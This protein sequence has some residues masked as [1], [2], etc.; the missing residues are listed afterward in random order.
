MIFCDMVEDS[1]VA[2]ERNIVGREPLSVH[3]IKANIGYGKEKY[4]TLNKNAPL[5]YLQ[6]GEEQY[7]KKEVSLSYNYLHRGMKNSRYFTGSLGYVY[8][9][10]FGDVTAT[11]FSSITTFDSANVRREY[12]KDKKGY[13]INKTPYEEF[14]NF[15]ADV[16][17]Q[18]FFG[19]N[20]TVGFDVGSNLSMQMRKAG[21]IHVWGAFLGL[22]YSA[23]KAED[24]T[25]K[26][27]FEALLKANDM[28]TADPARKDY[29]NFNQKLNF[30]IRFSVPISS[31]IFN[32]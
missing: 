15:K 4:N 25:T 14:N 3:W 9:N 32:K 16:Q 31:F 17:Y 27:S 10:N 6:D 18:M 13:D 22:I 20:R 26:Y 2:W 28:T 7:D 1:L 29:K 19:K 12:K 21:T 30:S 8:D 5:F 11:D 24:L 23:N